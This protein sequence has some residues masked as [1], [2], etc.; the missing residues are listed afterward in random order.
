MMMATGDFG[1]Q[2]EF[3]VE[4]IREG[5]AAELRRDLLK[6]QVMLIGFLS[7]PLAARNGQYQQEL[8]EVTAL[9][10]HPLLRPAVSP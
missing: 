3:L 5:W 8:D 7:K 10:Q 1:T 6:R 4:I 9:L 2:Y